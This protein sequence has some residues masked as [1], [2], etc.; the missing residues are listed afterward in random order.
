MKTV[1][2]RSQL[3]Q[4]LLICST[5]AT[6]NIVACEDIDAVLKDAED[7]RAL[8]QKLNKPQGIDLDLVERNLDQIER[9]E[10]ADTRTAVDRLTKTFMCQEVLGHIQREINKLEQCENQEDKRVEALT[11]KAGRLQGQIKAIEKELSSPQAKP[12]KKVASITKIISKADKADKKIVTNYNKLL[13]SGFIV[14]LAA[15]VL[16]YYYFGK[17]LAR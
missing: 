17:S 13:V 12:L 5:I 6:I 3:L 9:E 8:H 7:A 16:A 11:F 1:N 2:F 14:A 15:T 10:I 4:L